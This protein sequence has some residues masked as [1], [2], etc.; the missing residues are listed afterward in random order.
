MLGRG[1]EKQILHKSNI[2]LGFA[3]IRKD[4]CQE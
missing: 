4:V 2:N 1:F 3:L